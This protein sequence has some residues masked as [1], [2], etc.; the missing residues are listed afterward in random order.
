MQILLRTS[1]LPLA[2]FA[3]LV[4][5]P[6]PAAAQK[7][8]VLSDGRFEYE[9]N[10][11]ACHGDAGKGDGKLADI[12]ITRPPNLAGIAARNGGSFPFWKVYDIIAGETPVRAHK[13]SAMPIWGS[14][15][16]AEEKTRYAEPAHIRIL[17]LTHYLESIQEKPEK[18]EK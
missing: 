13:F 16:R 10:C 8:K 15:F 14:R 3:A 9:E 12:L 5:A 17:L 7:D 2:I 6:K 11:A 4:L 1:L 18:Q